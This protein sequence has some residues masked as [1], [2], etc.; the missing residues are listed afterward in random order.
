MVA[1]AQSCALLL[2]LDLSQVPQITNATLFAIFL[3][4]SH[5]R[6]LRICGNSNFTED[7]IPNLTNLIEQIAD[8]P[9]PDIESIPWYAKINGIRSIPASPTFEHLKLVDFTGCSSLTDLAID[10]LVTNAPKIRTLTLAKCTGLT[11]AAV[12]SISKLGRY[13]HYI[14]LGHVAQ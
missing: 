7:G 13:L 9:E 6:E 14:H 5:L 3:H 11:G 4:L 10:N 8:D 2:E 1:V 12:E